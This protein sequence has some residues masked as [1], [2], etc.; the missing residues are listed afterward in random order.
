MSSKGSTAGKMLSRGVQRTAPR[1]IRSASSRADFLASRGGQ[2]LRTATASYKARASRKQ[3]Q[4]HRSLVAIAIA[5]GVATISQHYISNGHLF[6]S[7]H[8]E[9]PAPEEE[10]S[11]VFEE[12]RKKQGVSKEENRDMISSQHHQVKRSWENPG[13]YA[14]GS[15]TGRVVA[16]ESSDNIVKTPRRIPF[17][18]GKLLRDVK[19]DRNFGAAIDER[20]DLLQW[21]NGYAPDTK[22]PVTTLRGK[23]LIALS[24]SRDRILGLSGNGKVYSLPV[25]AEDQAAG[26]KPSESTW[27]PFWSSSSPV[28]YRLLQPKDLSY[29]EK[30]TSLDSGL[31]HA[32]LL[33]SKG[34]LF[35][36]AA[37]SDSFPNR[38]QLGVS[39]LTFATRPDGPYDQ[40]H[41]ITT[42]RGFNIVKIACGDYHSLVLDKE[43]RVFSWG[44]NSSGQLGFDH[45]AESS[46]VDAPSLLPL[47]RLYAGTSQ[48][49]TVT[50]I[51]AGGNNSYMTVDAL[52][53]SAQ[54][55]GNLSVEDELKVNRG[56][57]KITADTWAFGQGITG[58]LANGRWTHVQSTPTKIPML[59]GLFEYDETNH[60]TIPIC[61]SHLSVG[62]THAAAVMHNVTYLSAS[63]KT[64]TDDTNWGADIVFWGGNEHYQLGTGRRNNMATPTYLQPL[65]M[66]AEIQ[67][68]K[69]STGGKE[70]H[71]FHI[72]PRAK[73]RLGDGR[74]KEVEQRVECGR[75]LTCVY[76]AT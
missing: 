10:K 45:S 14:W 44:D 17:F 12:S 49:P 70:E 33:T 31:E 51:F 15:N 62:S 63:D 61:L 74:V 42:L 73:A 9:A 58:S 29:S 54:T 20:G 26:V 65:D 11:L 66:A 64:S 8:A 47:Q 24:I 35:S 1:A 34:R 39:G 38:G 55:G 71:R 60:T 6:K 28:S 19:M 3:Q 23:N 25:S 53:V 27:I 37:S 67:R 40:P 21:G 57:G 5:G 30:V 69:K 36:T 76:S 59:S 48:V 2:P 22:V 32:L 4:L 75:G 43:G 18:N 56:L 46:I 68:A 50:K 52:K 72:T 16:P 7:T 13:V 41:E